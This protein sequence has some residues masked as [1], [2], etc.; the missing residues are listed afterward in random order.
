VTFKWQ[1]GSVVV[2]L[3]WPH[4]IAR[5]PKPPIRRKD[6]GYLLQNPNYSLFVSHFTAMA[7]R[8]SRGKISLAAFDGPTPNPPID[9]KIL[10][11]SQAEAEL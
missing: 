1:Q 11:I 7:T 3:D 6:L 5:A 8:K 9:A 4:S 10:Q 2:E